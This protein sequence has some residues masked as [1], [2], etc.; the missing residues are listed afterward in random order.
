MKVLGLQIDSKD[1]GQKRI[2]SAGDVL[3]GFRAER[4][5]GRR[6]GPAARS[7]FVLSS[8]HCGKLL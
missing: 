1:I 4:T 3:D 6:G 8:W 5:G 7:K 2:E